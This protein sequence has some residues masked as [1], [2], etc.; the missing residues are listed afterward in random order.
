[1]I[2]EVQ[3]GFLDALE[4]LDWMDESTRA[5]AIDKVGVLYTISHYIY[6]FVQDCSNSNGVTAVLH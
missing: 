1:M 2:H 6:G 5:E 4:V 3:N